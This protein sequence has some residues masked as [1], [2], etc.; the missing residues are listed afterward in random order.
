MRIDL[1]N[2][3]PSG[4][5]NAKFSPQRLGEHGDTLR[6]SLNLSVFSDSVVQLLHFN[7][8]PIANEGTSTAFLLPGTAI[9]KMIFS[10]LR[11]FNQLYYFVLIL[12]LDNSIK[13]KG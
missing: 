3:S 9:G 1:R 12:V 7:K 6:I 4:N 13:N 11:N 10:P 2:S 5:Q 8:G